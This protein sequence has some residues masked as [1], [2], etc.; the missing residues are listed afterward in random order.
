MSIWKPIETDILPM[1]DFETIFVNSSAKELNLILKTKSDNETN[2]LVQFS[3]LKLVAFEWTDE[4]LDAL[5]RD[6]ELQEPWP[7]LHKDGPKYTCPY[8]E[9]IESKWLRD[10]DPLPYHGARHF[11]F[12]SGSEMVDVIS[13][14]PP[15][16][17]KFAD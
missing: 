9:V 6:P 1:R 14:E 16:I 11:K 13:C 10:L 5:Q 3:R 15:V 8:V 12:I 2:V 4:C 17:K 7:L